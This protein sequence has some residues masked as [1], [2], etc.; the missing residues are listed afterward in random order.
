MQSNDS[1]DNWHVE[2]EAV[3]V[4]DSADRVRRILD[5]IL[6]AAARAKAEPLA[7]SGSKTDMSKGA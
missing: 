7:E 4:D 6:S 3:H 5:L 1:R 2:I